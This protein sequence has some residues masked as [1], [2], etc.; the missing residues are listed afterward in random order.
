M[1]DTSARRKPAAFIDRDGVLNHDDGY[2]GTHERF[3][4]M[5]GAA[6]AVRKLNDAGYFVFVI[7][8]QSGVAR[9]LFSERDVET[10]H[11]WMRG[12]LAAENARVDDVRYCPYH[13]DAPL[14]AYRQD[15]E[16]RKPK[17]GMILD[18]MR[19]WPV[20]RSG[21]FLIGDK[22]SDLR[23]STAVGINGFLF[24]GGNLADFVESCLAETSR[25]GQARECQ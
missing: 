17:P 23:A 8:N 18:L 5:P 4:W 10:L 16:W 1:S 14:P 15:S 11:D 2:I 7:S 12:E 22:E 24:G 13:P 9:G 21:S 25:K 3:R 20:E 6:S 19:A